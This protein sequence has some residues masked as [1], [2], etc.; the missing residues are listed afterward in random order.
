MV[1]PRLPSFLRF[2]RR[3]STWVFLACAALALLVFLPLGWGAVIFHRDMAHWTYPAREFLRASV[4]DRGHWPGWMPL[5]GLGFSVYGDPLY[6]LFYPPNWAY[7]GVGREHLANLMTGQVA[8]HVIW[9]G[10]GFFLLARGL[11]GTPKGSGVAALAW[12]LSGFV[13]AQVATGILTLAGAW[14]PWQAVGQLA[15]HE[16]V[17][18]GGRRWLSGVGKAALPVAFAF[19]LGEVFM[20][21]LGIGFG[22]GILLIRW[23]NE[24]RATRP[25]PRALSLAWVLSVLLGLWAAMAAIGP[26]FAARGSTERSAPLSRADA[27]VCSVHPL[28][29]LEFLLPHALGEDESNYPGA[30]YVGDSKLDGGPLTYNAYLGIS[31]LA[32]ALVALRRKER[33]TW[34]LGAGALLALLVSFGKYLPVHA[35]VRRVIPPL[36]FMRYPEKYML[37]V[38]AFLVP[39]SGLGAK[40]LL[41]GEGWVRVA[42][43]IPVAVGGLIVARRFAPPDL[44]PFLVG[45]AVLAILILAALAGVA[46][47]ARRYPRMAAPLLVILVGLDLANGRAGMDLWLPGREVAAVPVAAEVIRRDFA[48]Q[49]LAGP[50]RLFRANAVF[51]TIH[52]ALPSGKRQDKERLAMA[53]LVTNYAN[54]LGVATLPGYDVAVSP[55]FLRFWEA[56]RGKGQAVLRLLSANYVILPPPAAGHPERSGLLPLLDPVPGARLYRVLDPLPRVY[57]PAEVRPGPSTTAPGAWLD[58][59]VVSG[60]R[61]FVPL[62]SEGLAAAYPAPPGACAAR[63]W[64]DNRILAECRMEHPGLAVFVEQYANGWAALV[65]DK[66]APLV[67]TNLFMRG[68]PVPMGTHRVALTFTPPGLPLSLGVGVLG[69]MGIAGMLW[70]GRRPKPLTAGR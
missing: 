55:E 6:G 54:A 47:L 37:F 21:F 18:A 31:V 50:P 10:L 5:Q 41:A 32:L 33:L 70:F 69:W 19:L 45:G 35:M 2:S 15:L 49:G 24:P 23:L 20:A 58:P 16:A 56:A 14:V 29:V 59:A 46:V 61:A 27:E 11:G 52:A 51:N 7:L 40:R 44:G 66:P 22:A 57:V 28:R 38:L 43:M 48:K 26:T 34:L 39:L 8:A 13:G 42:G 9:G 25:R 4:A 17:R 62:D 60:R 3:E 53:T 65:D 63:T 1:S 68:V 30:R 36:A 12:M 67:R 64:S